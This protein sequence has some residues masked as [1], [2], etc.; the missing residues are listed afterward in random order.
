MRA[1]GVPATAATTGN[2]GR[3]LS[4]GASDRARD[5]NLSRHYVGALRDCPS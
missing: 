1:D 5:L 2:P 4:V 3:L